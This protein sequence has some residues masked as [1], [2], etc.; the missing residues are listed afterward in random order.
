M[1]TGLQLLRSRSD[2]A[3]QAVKA[4]ED[5]ITHVKEE[6]ATVKSKMSSLSDE[7]KELEKKIK[8]MKLQV[9]RCT[10]DEKVNF[11]VSAWHDY[12]LHFYIFYVFLVMPFLGRV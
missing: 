2:A 9:E 1:L 12:A 4:N 11:H 3:M 10:N 7:K 8:D 5:K 6:I